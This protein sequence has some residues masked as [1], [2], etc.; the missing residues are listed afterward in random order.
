MLHGLSAGPDVMGSRF[1]VENIG[2][3]VL[4]SV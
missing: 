2:Y 3:G 1:R 4:V